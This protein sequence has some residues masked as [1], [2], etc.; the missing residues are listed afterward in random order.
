MKKNYKIEKKDLKIGFIP[1]ICSAPLIYAH[2]H[3]IFEKNGLNVELMRPSGWSGIK[4]FIF[5]LFLFFLIIFN[6]FTK[7]LIFYLFLKFF[8]T[9]LFN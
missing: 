6:F 4:E 5:F 1:I 3:G 2:S 9:Y 8:I 7:F